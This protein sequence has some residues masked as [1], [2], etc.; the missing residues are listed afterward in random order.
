[1]TAVKQHIIIFMLLCFIPVSYSQ[2]SESRVALVIGNKNY[3][4]APLENPLNDARDMKAALEQVGFRVIYRENANLST[5][6]DAVHEFVKNLNKESVGL[7]YYS[8]HGAQADDGNYLIPVD[9]K[10]TSK[11]E[12]KSRAYDAG[13]IL[14]EMQEVGNKVNVVIL[15]ACRNNPFKGFK[16]GADGLATMSGPKGSLIAYATAPGSVAGDG[17]SGHNGIYTA[18]LKQYI[19]QPGL[20]IEEMFKKVR[21]SVV[22]KNPD[23]TPW[24]NSSMTGDFCFA[25]CAPSPQPARE[26]A[27]S[28]ALDP[29]SI[30]LSFWNSIKDSGNPADFK[31]YLTKYPKGQF[32]S[33]AH[34]RLKPSAPPAQPTEKPAADTNPAAVELSFWDSIKDSNNPSDFRAY[35]EQYPQGKFASLARNRLSRPEPSPI[36]QTTTIHPVPAAQAPAMTFDDADQR[37]NLESMRRAIEQAKTA[38]EE[39]I[40]Q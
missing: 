3:P 29:A 23:Q 27:V 38:R 21:Q 24:E 25:G 6:D 34:N 1:M 28:P 30:E 9:A 26:E 5:M 8:G 14:G 20:K 37:A 35:L 11:A 15:D 17:A 33:I 40:N 18:Y 19:V 39:K 7:V 4:K 13:I 36:A 12:L 22:D 2:A 31:A 16:G 32:E 10:I